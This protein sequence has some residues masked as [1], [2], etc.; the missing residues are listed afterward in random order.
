MCKLLKSNIDLSN[1]IYSCF[2]PKSKEKK[3]KKPI[4]GILCLSAWPQSNNY[5]NRM[6]NKHLCLVLTELIRLKIVAQ[7]KTFLSFFINEG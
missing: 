7:Y 1:I 2:K 6:D 5:K 4:P 3:E